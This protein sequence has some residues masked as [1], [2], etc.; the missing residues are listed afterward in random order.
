M[1]MLGM[2]NLMLNHCLENC[3][4]GLK[5]ICFPKQNKNR[6]HLGGGVQFSL[7][8]VLTFEKLIFVQ[9]TDIQTVVV[10]ICVDFCSVTISF[11]EDLYQT[12]KYVQTLETDERVGNNGAI[13]GLNVQDK[14]GCAVGCV[15][16]FENI[17][18]VYVHVSTKDQPRFER[19]DCRGQVLS[20]ERI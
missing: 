2:W 9:Y 8:I 13:I 16:P 3:L 17:F 12:T 1:V 14:N 10:G 5:S 20:N 19:G 18:S 6:A 15:N 7:Y 4:F 11:S